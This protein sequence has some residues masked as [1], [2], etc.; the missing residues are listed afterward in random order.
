MKGFMKRRVAFDHLNAS[1]SGAFDIPDRR[2]K[3]AKMSWF[4]VHARLADTGESPSGSTSK[5]SRG[6]S[7]NSVSATEVL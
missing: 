3:I 6:F 2:S 4:D 1:L 7:Y 5:I